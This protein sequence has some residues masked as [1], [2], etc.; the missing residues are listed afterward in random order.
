MHTAQNKNTH[1]QIKHQPALQHG[2]EAKVRDKP[3]ARKPLLCSRS[4]ARVASCTSGGK[5]GKSTDR[6]RTSRLN[7]MLLKPGERPTNCTARGTLAAE[8]LGSNP[9]PPLMHTTL[10]RAQ[11][12]QGG[13][14]PAASAK[15]AF[16]RT[17]LAVDHCEA[18]ITTSVKTLQWPLRSRLPEKALPLTWPRYPQ[19]LPNVRR[20][21]R[22]W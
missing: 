3:R 17:V 9:I 5:S 4:S 8:K 20:F 15:V 10:V 13:K 19:A 18:D 21:R 12:F 7:D 14:P 2:R 11:R 1:G 16:C 22:P 6:N